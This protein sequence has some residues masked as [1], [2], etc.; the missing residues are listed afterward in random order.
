VL[1]GLRNFYESTPA[2]TPG[3]LAPFHDVAR[4][5]PAYQRFLAAHG[6]DPVAIRTVEDFAGLP[7]L[8]KETY[9]R[10]YP[11]PELC[12]DGRLDAGDMVAVSSGSSGQPTVW[13][14]SVLDE[15][16]VAGR[17]EQVLRGSF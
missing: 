7:L 3:A 9:Q 10:R 13:P 17:F 4:R 16:P 1:A 5:V 12:R 14:R 15:L 11:L 8:T 6:V 2:G